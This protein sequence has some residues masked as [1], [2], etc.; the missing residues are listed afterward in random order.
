ML[1]WMVETN[2]DKQRTNK[3]K[4]NKQKDKLDEQNQKKQI[5]LNANAP[6]VNDSLFTREMQSQAQAGKP[7]GHKQERRKQASQ[8]RQGK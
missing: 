5:K 2:K 7:A 4:T 3:N 6:E 8:A 1:R